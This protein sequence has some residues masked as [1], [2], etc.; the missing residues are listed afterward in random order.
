L[1]SLVFFLCKRAL[2]FFL[3]NYCSLKEISAL[4]E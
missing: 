4:G 2:P 3:I 1:F